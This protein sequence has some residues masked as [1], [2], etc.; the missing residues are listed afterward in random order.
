MKP[1]TR[2][3]KLLGAK[4]FLHMPGVYDPV[5][6]LLVG[7]NGFAVGRRPSP[8][9]MIECICSRAGKVSRLDGSNKG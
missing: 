4:T 2:L 5:G 3:R 7:L 8:R 1:T 6:A 9:G